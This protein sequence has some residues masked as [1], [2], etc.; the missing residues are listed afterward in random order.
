MIKNKPNLGD[1]K[2]QELKKE[3]AEEPLKMISFQAPESLRA[4][5]K[6]RAAEN[7]EKM[8]DVLVEF[9]NNYINK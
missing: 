5:F 6:A 1:R 8:G 3:A 2:Y 4:K 7:N 9:M